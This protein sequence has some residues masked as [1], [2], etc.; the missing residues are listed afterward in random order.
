MTNS[1]KRALG[2]Q[3]SADTDRSSP[4]HPRRLLSLRLARRAREQISD[5][6]C[7][8]PRY[9]LQRHFYITAR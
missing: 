3:L 7:R 4:Y 5:R 1:I 2:A 6:L 8:Q 9:L